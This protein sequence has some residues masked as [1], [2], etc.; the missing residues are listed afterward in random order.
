MAWNPRPWA[1]ALSLVTSGCGITSPRAL[2]L[3]IQVDGDTVS[4]ASPVQVTV[5]AKNLGAGTLKVTSHG[6]PQAFE[7]LAGDEDSSVG[8]EP[9]I[10]T[11][12]AFPPT[13][14]A[15]GDSLVFQYVWKGDGSS[16]TPLP[17]GNYRLRGW[18]DLSSGDRVFSDSKSIEVAS[19]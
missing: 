8:P 19:S 2:R 12:I 17:D 4:A 1:L 16:G 13:R 18:V 15:P 6:C 11:L 10:C 7:V 5:V 14:L 9:A 3:S